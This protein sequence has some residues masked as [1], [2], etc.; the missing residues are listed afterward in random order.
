MLKDPL[1]NIKLLLL[2]VC[3]G[4]EVAFKAIFNFYKE[5]FFAASFRMTHSKDIAEEIVQ[6]VFV[7]LWIK[8]AQVAAAINPES[9]LFT[10]LHN[11]I[12]AHF[13]KLALEKTLRQTIT[14]QSE[15]NI[16]SP[17]EEILL[18]KENRQILETLI[19]Q[20]PRQQ[21]IVYQLSKQQG[22]SRD[23]IAAQLSISPHTVKNHLQQAMQ[24]IRAY[25]K[26]GASAF[27]W[28]AIWHSL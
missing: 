3:E 2:Q 22:L 19:N 15:I 28:I 6:E 23:E 10:M 16:A 11:S 27:I 17:V 24:F 18:A 26:A 5:R 8:R 9:Y 20:L 7:N 21:R 25:Y 13:R 12:F 1:H 14:Q 4:N